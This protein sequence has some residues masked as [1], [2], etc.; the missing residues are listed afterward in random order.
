[1][2]LC[3]DCSLILIVYTSTA[4]LYAATITGADPMYKV[5]A[6]RYSL[7]CQ[8]EDCCSVCNCTTSCLCRCMCSKALVCT[9]QAITAALPLLRE[10]VPAHVLVGASANGFKTSTSEW[11]GAGTT[12]GI[13]VADGEF[14]HVQ[15]IC[16][17][18]PASALYACVATTIHV[19]SAFPSWLLRLIGLTGHLHIK[20]FSWAGYTE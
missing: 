10:L 9:L 15:H 4:D 17:Y 6:S 18:V 13:G 12:P 16:S 2:H 1:M 8:L 19:G 20:H 5:A 3:T 14:I 7:G 11:L